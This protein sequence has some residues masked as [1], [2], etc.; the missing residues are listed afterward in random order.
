MLSLG[1]GGAEKVVSL[2]LKKLKN[3]YNVTLV[4]FYDVIHFQIPQEVSIV[5]LSRNQSSI[6]FYS[7]IFTF[8]FLFKYF[9]F[10]NKENIEISVSFLPVPNFING[11]LAII[12]KKPKYFI[13]ERGFPTTDTT[14]KF[15]MLISKILYPILYN[16]CDALFSNSIHI[17]KDLK[18]NFG[19]TIPMEVIY[20]PIEAP[21]YTIIPKTQAYKIKSFNIIS[22]GSLDENKN[23]IMIL[24]ALSKINS[25]YVNLTILGDGE[26]CEYLE[27]MKIELNLNKRVKLH[28]KV[29]NVNDYL[30]QGNCFVLSSFSE[31]FPN[32]LLEAM[33]IG[34]PCISTNC[35]SGP[36]ELLN[37]NEEA[38]INYGEYYIGKFG[39][40]I[41]CDDHLGLQK[42]I[43]YYRDHPEQR[44]RFSGLSL[45]RSKDYLIDNIYP[46]F[47][48]FIR[49]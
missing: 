18:D 39:I 7:K 4:L 44:E 32:A 25:N 49:F 23:H 2:L 21:F 8:N 30:L 33:A 9:S 14:G 38:V 40:L 10:I 12:L 17:N 15:S 35:L 42:A 46:I 3:D 43:E 29:K 11:I 45:Q 34:L 36:L 5:I 1:N 24:R 37:N 26:L 22:V 27:D 20:N 41:N 13:S 47:K 48:N 19:I 28:G 16:Q 31:G 6:S